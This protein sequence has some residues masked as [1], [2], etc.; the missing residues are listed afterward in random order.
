MFS[1]WTKPEI[2]KK[3]HLVQSTGSVPI[4]RIPF[5]GQ[6]YSVPAPWGLIYSTSMVWLNTM[7]NLHNNMRIYSW[8]V[9]CITDIAFSYSVIVTIKCLSTRYIEEMVKYVSMVE[10]WLDMSSVW[11]YWFALL[12]LLL[13]LLLLWHICISDVTSS[14]V[15]P[16]PGTIP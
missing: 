14:L 15:R 4:S 10:K 11:N 9:T 5:N 8:R 12:L 13:L 3:K 16:L 7:T 6:I 1:I 2:I